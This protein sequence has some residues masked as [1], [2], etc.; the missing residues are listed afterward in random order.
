[1]SRGFSLFFPSFLCFHY[2]V[3][4]KSKTDEVG[5]LRTKW[6]SPL[7]LEKDNGCLEL[8]RVELDVTKIEKW[9]RKKNNLKEAFDGKSKSGALK[10]KGL[11][12]VTDA[13]R[14]SDKVWGSSLTAQSWKTYKCD[15]KFLNS[16]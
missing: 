15:K 4:L 3:A 13:E 2:L 16:V 7:W 6:E 8:I 5:L 10:E 9:K 14:N 12:W 11:D 1:M